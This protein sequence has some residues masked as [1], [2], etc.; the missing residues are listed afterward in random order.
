MTPPLSFVVPVLNESA[1]IASLLRDLRQRYPDAELIVVDGGSDDSTVREA[2]P[3]CDQLLLSAPGRAA[4]MNLGASV[5][6][7]DYVVFLHADSIPSI[8]ADRLAQALAENPL[9]GF[10]RL[11]LSGDNRLFRIIEWSINKR[12]ALT[13]VATGDQMIF[14]H[15]ERFLSLGGYADMPLMEDVD[16]CKRLR[17]HEAPVVETEPV[18]T[19]S[20]R[21]EQGGIVRTVLIMWGLRLAYFF[22]VSPQR[23]HGYY[24]GR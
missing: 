24:Y 20:R 17:R 9:W 1:D 18:T 5:A 4:Q 7:G 22:G 2:M 6:R 11:R 23:L 8:S 14:V 10:C 16:L 21:W 19:S 3:G 13:R 15:R 12:S